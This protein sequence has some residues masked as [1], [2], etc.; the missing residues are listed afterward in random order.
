MEKKVAIIDERK[1]LGKEFRMYGTFDEPLFLAKDVA[2]WIDYSK[3][4]NGAY[5]VSKMLKTVDEDEK[6]VRTI[7][8]SGQNREMWFLTEDGLYEV[9]MQSRKPIARVFKKKVKEILKEVRKT[10]AYVP[11]GNTM[12]DALKAIVAQFEEQNARM[13]AIEKGIDDTR[14][15]CADMYE[16]VETLQAKMDA[17]VEKERPKGS[18]TLTEAAEWLGLYTKDKFPHATMAGAIARACGIPVS[19]KNVVNNK[20]SCTMVRMVNGTKQL[21]IYIKPDGLACMKGWWKSNKT[22]LYKALSYQR[23]YTGRNGEIHEPGDFRDCFYEI[24][25]RKYH[26]DPNLVESV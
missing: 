11:S 16:K 7:F 9:L 10:G 24:D 15:A 5:D 20:Y 3:T 17:D 23:H 26:V 25:G 14:E 1:V 8:V 22:M 12:L 6:L 19:Y 2:E 18:K 4:G 13:D 21:I